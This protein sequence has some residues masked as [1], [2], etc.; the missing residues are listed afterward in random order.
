MKLA[1]MQPYF[2]PYIGYFQLINAVDSFVLYDNIQFTKKGWINRNRI[3]VNGND[4]FITIPLKKD[5]DFLCVNQRALS[6][7]WSQD[8]RKLLNRLIESYRKAPYFK[9]NFEVIES[10]LFFNDLNLF[11]YIFNS[12]NNIISHLE[13][14]TKIIISSQVDI[15]HKLKSEEKVISICNKLNTEI[16]VNPIGGLDLYNSNNFKNKNI[17]LKFH[18]SNPIIY[19]QYNES[20]IPWLSII[21]I[22]MFNSKNDIQL[23]LNNYQLIE[24]E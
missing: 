21:D 16:Y 12:I 11:N 10:S 20:F 8:R 13:I 3:L 22:L 14:K 15:D 19:N 24:N 1:I 6:D 5:S 17:K 2:F 23:F 9:Y 18:K 7:T 4:E